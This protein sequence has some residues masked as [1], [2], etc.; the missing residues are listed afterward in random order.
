M[1]SGSILLL[2]S[3]T[4]S[5]YEP[6]LSVFDIILSRCYPFI[7]FDK[8]SPSD[9]TRPEAQHITCPEDDHSV[10]LWLNCTTIG[11]L[12]A[13]HKSFI[14]NYVANTL[15]EHPVNGICF[16]IFPNRA[17]MQDGGG[18][19]PSNTSQTKHLILMM[20]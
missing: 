14:Y 16:V 12:G 15:S 20:T 9:I 18:R 10:V 8:G 19:T 4:T 7:F 2:L 5:W 3:S 1:F 6:P 17:G 11:I 13:H